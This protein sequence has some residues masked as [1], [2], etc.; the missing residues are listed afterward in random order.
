[1][2]N[3]IKDFDQF[4]EEHANAVTQALRNRSEE[5]GSLQNRLLEAEGSIDAY[6]KEAEHAASKQALEAEFPDFFADLPED[7]AG[8]ASEVPIQGD[9]FR[10]QLAQLILKKGA[11]PAG[12]KQLKYDTKQVSEKPSM[13][14]AEVSSPHFGKSYEGDPSKSKKGAEDNAALKALEAEFAGDFDPNSSPTTSLARAKQGKKRKA[15]SDNQVDTDPRQ[16]LIH[17]LQIFAQWSSGMGDT[18]SSQVPFPTPWVSLLI[19]LSSKIA[20]ELMPSAC[21]TCSL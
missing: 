5:M 20:Q 2:K 9:S 21:W 10:Y 15:E 19:A 12:E 11:P 18:L 1:L 7:D 17:S 16:Q 14:T 6:K 8:G 3:T 4:K 13:F